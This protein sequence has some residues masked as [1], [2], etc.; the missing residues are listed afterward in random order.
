MTE[1]GCEV[2]EGVRDDSG[3]MYGDAVIDRKMLEKQAVWKIRNYIF[4]I[5]SA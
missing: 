1:C 3:F 5:C 2:K 4:Q